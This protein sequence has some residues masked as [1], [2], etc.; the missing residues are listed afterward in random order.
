MEWSSCALRTRVGLQT[1]HCPGANAR[2]LKTEFIAIASRDSVILPTT[3]A[4][5]A[6]GGV[7]MVERREVGLAV[8]IDKRTSG[9]L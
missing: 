3:K 1:T 8:T 7:V 9:R 5:V 6:A 2:P 4:A